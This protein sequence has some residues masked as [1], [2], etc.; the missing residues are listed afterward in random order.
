MEFFKAL[1]YKLCNQSGIHSFLIQII[2]F[3]H[4]S[5]KYFQKIYNMALPLRASIFV[6][7]S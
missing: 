6:Y 5:K 3:E 7:H 4:M 1:T 2:N